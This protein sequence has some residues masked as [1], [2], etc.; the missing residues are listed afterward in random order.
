MEQTT[1]Y[2]SISEVMEITSCGQTFIRSEIQK[3]NLR[4]YKVRNLIRMRE[5]DVRAW[6]EHHPYTA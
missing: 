1:K 6:I 2:L 5:S 3:G 4:A